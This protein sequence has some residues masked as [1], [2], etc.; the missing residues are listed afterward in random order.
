MEVVYFLTRNFTF[1]VYALLIISF[2]IGIRIAPRNQLHEEKGFSLEAMTSLKGI[3][4][5][6]VLCHHISQKR[7]FQ[8]VHI[9]PIFEF[10]GFLFVGIF[11]FC[12]GYGLYKSFSTKENYLKGFPKKRILPIVISYFVMIALYAAYY[13][14]VG[15]NFTPAQW[16][17]KLTGLILINSQSWYVYVIIIMYVAFYLI[18][19][20]EKLRKDGAFILLVIALLQGAL[21]LF[22]GHFPWWLG[23]KDWWKNGGLW[24][25]PWWKSPVALL[26]EGEWWVNSTVAFAL[27]VFMAEKEK[28]FVEWAKSFYWLKLVL[29]GLICAGVT[30]AGIM[31]LWN[32]GYWSDMGGDLGFWKK[33]VTYLVQCVQII[34][35]C[36]FVVMLM[37]KFYVSN[38][39]YRLYGKLSLEVY[40][41][42]EMI[43]F[44]WAYLIEKSAG[45]QVAPIFAYANWNAAAY[46]I[47]VFLTVTVSALVYHW[48]NALLTK[49]LKK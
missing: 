2:V 21:F 5:L 38:R 10:I 49:P 20:N 45:H 42:Q 8:E 13:L 36:I 3:M 16:I 7:L 37:Q 1:I 4:A 23:P 18:Y 41:I 24:S 40:L 14:I 29:V 32:V 46:A 11:F 26:F 12:S 43:L 39:F 48:I 17:L 30:Y 33:T 28:A 27:G 47:L 15:N 44:S 35:T 9:I 25:A 6:F 22:N 34:V 19:K 31:S